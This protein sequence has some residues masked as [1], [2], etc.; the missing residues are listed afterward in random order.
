MPQHDPVNMKEEMS[1]FDLGLSYEAAAH[2]IQS[3]YAYEL[4][5]QGENQLPGKFHPK[6]MRVGI[7]LSK[8]DAM[9]LAALLIDKGLITWAEY[10]EYVR[11]AANQELHSQQKKHGATFL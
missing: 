8:S 3:S 9:G 10:L 11:L 1:K 5:S 7:D 6:H 2:G 4:G